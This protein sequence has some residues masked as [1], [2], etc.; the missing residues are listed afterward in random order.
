MEPQLRLDATPYLGMS[1]R[2]DPMKHKKKIPDLAF[3][4]GRGSSPAET[5][6]L[7]ELWT[8]EVAVRIGTWGPDASQQWMSI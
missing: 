1:D 7:F 6:R 4:Q 5:R 3:P 8:A 2:F